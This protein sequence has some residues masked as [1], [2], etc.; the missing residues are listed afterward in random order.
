M[1]DAPN[2]GQGQADLSVDTCEFN[3]QMFLIEQALA[4]I[5]GSTLVRV[6]ACTTNDQ[7]GPIGFVDVQPL[8]NM[9]NGA[10]VAQQ[11][12]VISKLCFSRVSA[13]HDAVICDPVPGDIGLAIFADRDI[14]S[15]K[16][17]Q[18]ISN[19]GT[20]RRNSMS[21]GIYLFTVMSKG[22]PT[23][24]IRFV[25]DNDGN[26]TGIT[27]QDVNNNTI[28]M[29]TNGVTIN[30]VLIDRSQNISKAAKI[31][32]T[33]EI[34]GKSGSGGSVTLTE[35]KHGTGSPAAGTSVPTGGT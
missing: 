31:D 26:P 1:A 22:N 8:V 18:N 11:H 7:V 5:A 2:P 13:G 19:P 35:H 6:E 27:I 14:S 21:D 25:R 32:A 15:V 12:G 20:F 23:Q 16:A 33:A 24:F 3:A 4:L 34:T 28:V 30:G 9:I 10:A 17:S 29:D